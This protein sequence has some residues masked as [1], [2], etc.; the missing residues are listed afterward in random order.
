[1]AIE[2]NLKH[3]NTMNVYQFD[4]S[5]TNFTVEEL[6]AVPGSRQQNY[7]VLLDERKCDCGYFQALHIHCRHVLAACSH[8]RLDWKRFVHPVYHMESVFNIYRSEF[9]PIGHEDDWP[10]YDGPRI[11][12]KHQT[13]R[14]Q[15]GRPV[16]SRIRNNMDDVKHNGEKQCGLCRQSRHT[17]R[18]CTAL[19]GGGASSSR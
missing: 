19:G 7:Q 16:S 10:S 15:R 3:V 18:T 1:M 8:A 2:F 4:Q 9:R 17:R 13:M 5:K 6:A 11:H 12:P 14:V